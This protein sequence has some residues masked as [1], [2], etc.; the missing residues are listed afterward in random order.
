MTE[1]RLGSITSSHGIKG[2]F[3][4]FSYTDPIEKIFDYSPWILRKGNEERRVE[5]RNG[6][7][8]GKRLIASV[9]GIENRT[10]ADDLAGYEIHVARAL[11]PE[12]GEGDFYWFQLEG[13]SVFN[14]EGLNLGEVSHMIETGANDV[15]SVRPT[16]NSIDNQE[17]LIPYV[18]H[19]VVLS[20]DPE[21]STIVVDWR[22]EF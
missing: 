22:A 20:V 8:H 15:M 18:E 14:R 6:Q 9:A 11:L 1:I 2:W 17:R 19:D 7:Q 4:V 3:K 21:A 13:L 10:Q 16:K 5:I 12:L